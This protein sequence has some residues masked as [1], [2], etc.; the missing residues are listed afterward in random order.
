MYGFLIEQRLTW[1]VL[2]CLMAVVSLL[3]GVE[4]MNLCFLVVQT[5]VPPW[6]SWRLIVQIGML[7]WCCSCLAYQ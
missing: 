5:A 3:M 2:I 1:S 4:Q 6:D 7:C